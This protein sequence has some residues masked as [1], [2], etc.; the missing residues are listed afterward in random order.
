[1]RQILRR[2]VN[3]LLHIVKRGFQGWVL[4]IIAMLETRMS[5]KNGSLKI[6]SN[7]KQTKNN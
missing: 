4:K 2:M 7:V 5:S 6:V 3:V 1:M